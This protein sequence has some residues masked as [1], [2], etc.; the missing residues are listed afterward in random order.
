MKRKTAYQSL[1]EEADKWVTA[2]VV[3]RQGG[4]CLRAGCYPP[5]CGGGMQGAHILRKGGM[6]NSIRFDLE[7]VLGM[8][9]N[10][11]IYWAHKNE[12][13]FYEWVE[14]MFPGRIAKLKQAALMSSGK[15]DLK[16]LICVLKSIAKQ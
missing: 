1:V 4:K 6:Y 11:H 9:R 14:E 10:H 2:I 5:S 8:C 16:E 12:L 7:N 15:I 13:A 3:R